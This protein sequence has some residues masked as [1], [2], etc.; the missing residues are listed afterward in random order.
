MKRIL[1][2]A[3]LVL[4]PLARTQPLPPPAIR[5]NGIVNAASRIPST[6]PGGALAAGAKVEIFGVR[7][8]PPARLRVRIF[9]SDQSWYA[10]VI[11]SRPEQ[12]E[13]RLPEAVRPG[14]AKVMVIAD[15]LPS[16]AFPIRIAISNPGLYSRNGLGWGQGVIQNIDPSGKRSENSRQN[17]AQPGWRVAAIATG[18]SSNRTASVLIGGHV[19]QGH[20]KSAGGQEQVDFVIPAG[21]PEGCDVPLAVRAAPGR[22]S[23]VVTLAIHSGPGPCR[24]TI[25]DG[26]EHGPVAIGALSRVRTK[27]PL[28]DDS[29]ADEA[30]FVAAN[31]DRADLPP[32]LR[33]PPAGTCAAYLTSLDS[34]TVVPNSIPVALAMLLRGQDESKGR[35]LDV[36][37]QIELTRPGAERVVRSE[38]NVSGYYH[39]RLGMAGVG[40]NRRLPLFLDPGNIV[41][42]SPGGKDVGAAHVPLRIPAPLE[43]IE[44]DAFDP[45]DRSRPLTLRWRNAPDSLIVAV[46]TNTDAM[47]TAS[48]TCL[49]VADGGKGALT[50]PAEFLS[51]LPGSTPESGN[52]YG[53]VFLSSI[54]NSATFA[55]RGIHR[56][57]WFYID[58]EVRPAEF[59]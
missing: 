45:I 38:R 19:T 32:L 21:I 20:M 18:F 50:V 30:N 26:L 33:L 27:I 10:P 1:A 46:V 37:T 41:A 25:L 4:A 35:G 11:E 54:H 31:G 23:N 22:A 5:Q 53:R 8:A 42:D 16:A 14:D 29:I 51:H 13:V 3:A 43:W 59:R 15:G 9:T 56:G 36:G 28:G 47:T 6:L 52:V 40:A 49:C 2:T 12:L 55:A 57:V 24:S 58:G 44:G 7:F 48:G 17:P 34:D 39:A